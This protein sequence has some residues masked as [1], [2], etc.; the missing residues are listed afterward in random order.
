MSDSE[1]QLIL[2]DIRALEDALSRKTESHQIS[3]VSFKKET[4]PPTVHHP[5]KIE[6]DLPISESVPIND[7]QTIENTVES[8]FDPAE[9]LELNQKLIE[10][11]IATRSEVAEILEECKRKRGVVSIKIKQRLRQLPNPKI[12]SSHAG[13][14]YFKDKDF[15]TAPANEDTKLKE[16]RGQLQIIHLRRVSRWTVK[17]KETLLKAIHHEVVAG[18]K[19]LDEEEVDAV[20]KMTLGKSHSLPAVVTDA[21]GRL[22][23]REFDWMK[24][25]VIDFQNK[26]SPEECRVM[27][28]VFLHPDINKFKW[29]KKELS[30]LHTLAKNYKYQ[31]WDEIAKELGTQRSGYQCFVKYNTTK[32]TQINERPWAKKEDTKLVHLVN[33]FKIGDFINWGDIASCMENRTKQQIYFRWMYSLAPHLKKGRFTDEE[34]KLLINAIEKYGPNFKKISALVLPTRTSAQLSDHYNTITSNRGENAWT[35]EQDSKLLALYAEHGNDWAKIASLFVNKDRVQLRHRYS[36]LIRY[37]KR[38]MSLDDIPRDNSRQKTFQKSIVFQKIPRN[39]TQNL[40]QLQ[41]VDEVDREIIDYFQKF[42]TPAAKAGRRKKFYQDSEL[43]SLSRKMHN[44]LAFLNAKLNIPY[45]L[46]TYDSLTEKDK[47]LLHS[48]K[49][50]AHD[51]AHGGAP[52]RKAEQMR[53]AMFGFGEQEG[54]GQEEDE[55]FIPPL[56]FGVRGRKD[57]FDQ[58][59]NYSPFSEEERF[60]EARQMYFETPYSIIEAIGEGVNHGFDK[61]GKLLAQPNYKSEKQIVNS[62]YVLTPRQLAIRELANPRQ[63]V[64]NFPK[65]STS[66]TMNSDVT[67]L[68]TFQNHFACKVFDVDGIPTMKP[69]YWTLLGYQQILIAMKQMNPENN[70]IDC[71]EFGSKIREKG[72][73]ALE[74]LR[75]RL[76]QLFKYPLIMSQVLPPESFQA[77]DMFFLQQGK[78]KLDAG[79]QSGAK[80]KKR[81]N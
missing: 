48:L 13:M 52:S 66:S 2:D 67:L 60:L 30:D 17:D 42:N 39:N 47:Q 76:V 54:D 26:H 69:N 63:V 9:A 78:R 27:W 11:L 61:L 16:A 19:D 4:N 51:A 68:G 25:A 72:R 79:K 18:L 77:G 40:C 15:F 22:G 71:A 70:V 45:D 64:R 33:K 55:H 41:G 57:R 8:S 12:L 23:K 34:D 74:T 44:L 29:K 80:R 6:I 21:I 5:R 53:I 36:A 49:N 43:Q 75:M 24:I 58:V 38:G 46:E 59:I 73:I 62:I 14:P 20:E 7:Q 31:N 3:E 56:P 50:L 10:R 1:D 28:N 65:A 37:K 35:V 81:R 32:K